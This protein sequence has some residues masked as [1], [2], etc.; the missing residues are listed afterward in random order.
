MTLGAHSLGGGKGRGAIA[1][2]LLSLALGG[3]A[4]EEP[5]SVPVACKS[6]PEAVR[7]ALS[8]APEPVRL[9][10]VPL[11]GCLT[12]ASDSADLQ[13]VGA[14]Y[15]EVA[16][17]LAREARRDPEAA[18]AEQLGYLTGAV[19]R[20]AAATQGIHDELRRRLEQELSVVDT[21]S[22]AFQEGERAG[23]ATG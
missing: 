19:R 23:R 9:D 5:A 8:S 6:G 1:L 16:A 20:G 2:S 22:A 3:C 18:A 14:S 17:E 4:S 11:S 7:L 15:V 13:A 21:G 10:G 12:R